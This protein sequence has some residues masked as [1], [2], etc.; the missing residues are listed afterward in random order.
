MTIEDSDALIVVD[1]QV[2]F[3]P[4]GAL[5][6]TGGNEIV[7]V[8]NRL[9]PRFQCH[10]YTR[11]WHPADHC[12][13][14]ETPQWVDG[15]WPR[16]CVRDTPGAAFHPDLAVLPGALIVSKAEHRDRDA[17]S[18]FDGTELA[19][20]LREMNIRRAFVCGLAT[21]YCV[22]ATALD[23]VKHGFEAILIEDACRGVDLPAG[24]VARA[25]EEMR[26][27]G[28]TKCSSGDLA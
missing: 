10:V 19:A 3:C 25:V 21:D 24:S 4:G 5:A 20:T 6:V 22:K 23:G 27:A 18:G 11:D 12:C 9:A 26:A 1:V 15:S 2:D 7:P 28:V 17:Y 13:F 14:S 8:I 16:H